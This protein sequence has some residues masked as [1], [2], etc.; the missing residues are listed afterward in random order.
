LFGSGA[1]ASVVFPPLIAASCPQFPT[2]NAPGVLCEDFE[3]ER[4]GIPNIQFNRLPVGVDPLD[5]LLVLGDPND[6]ILGF[7]MD[8]RPIANF[9]IAGTSCTADIPYN[10]STCAGPVAVENDWHLHTAAAAENSDPNMNEGYQ[11]TPGSPSYAPDGGKAHSGS[12]SMHWGRHLYRLAGQETDTTRFRQV[13][14]FVLETPIN[15]GP[16]SGLEMWH[17][18]Q[19]PD[20]DSFGFTIPG[21]TFSGG[22]VQISLLGSDGLYEKWRPLD[23][24]FNGPNSLLQGQITICAF[25]PGDDLFP[26]LDETSCTGHAVWSDIG[27]IIGIDATCTTD[28]DGNDPVDLDCGEIRSCTGNA[29]GA[30][31]PAPGGEDCTENGSVGTGVWARSAFDLSPFAGRRARIRWIG[32]MGGGWSFGISRSFLEGPGPGYYL[33]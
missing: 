24:T 33:W 14:A 30:P 17:M 22:Q 7:T 27:D 26:P 5:P 29:G 6:D 12:R 9:G 25:D 1:S 32:M 28:T 18:I 16:S 3:T 4:N 23:A 15:L 2:I 20:D 21:T 8:S 31:W 11:A 13:S 10:Q 19:V